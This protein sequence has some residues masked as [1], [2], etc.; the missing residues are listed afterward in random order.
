[1]QTD[2]DSTGRNAGLDDEDVETGR[3]ERFDLDDLL[4][5]TSE[6]PALDEETGKNL[7]IRDADEQGNTDVDIDIDASLLDATGQTQVLSGDTLEQRG[8]ALRDDEKTMLSPAF[9]NDAETLLASIDDVDGEDYAATA[10]LSGDNA[11]DFD[12]AKTEAL[13]KDVFGR[14]G[15]TDETGEM[16]VGS[17]DVDLDLDDLTNALRFSEG[18]TIDQPRDDATIEQRLGGRDHNL[19]DIDLG[20]A[21]DMNDDA[22]TEALSPDE[23]SDDLH[24]A[25]TM[26]EV[27]TK[28]DLARAYVDMGDPD[29][30]RSILEEVLDEGDDG[31]RQQAQKLIE[32][33]PA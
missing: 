23:L 7:A 8:R 11:I 14:N 1:L 20:D 21:G 6:I 15:S 4:G 12:F 13:P 27:G 10:A 25:R 19:L 2:L 18:D 30:A 3:H 33:L 5:A 22:P 26:T 32:S 31:Q 29:G 28:L 9:D 17:T 24:D 16:P